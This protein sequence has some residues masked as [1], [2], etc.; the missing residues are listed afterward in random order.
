MSQLLWMHE[1]FLVLNLCWKPEKPKDLS[2]GQ[3]EILV[4]TVTSRENVARFARSQKWD[5]AIEQYEGGYK[6]VLTK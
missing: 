6:V 5:V 2:G 4:D 3:V 1:A